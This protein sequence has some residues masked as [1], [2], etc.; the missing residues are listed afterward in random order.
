MRPAHNTRRPVHRVGEIS[1]PGKGTTQRIGDALNQLPTADQTTIR[2]ALPALARL[3]D[4][5]VSPTAEKTAAVA[6][7]RLE[8]PS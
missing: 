7:R 5:L 8:L 2:T 3:V 6:V 4:H 1:Q